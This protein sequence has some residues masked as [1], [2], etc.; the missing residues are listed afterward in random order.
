[1][2]RSIYNLLFLTCFGISAPFYFLRLRRRGNWRPNFGERFGHYDAKIKQ[3]LTNRQTIWM[4]AVSVGEVQVC[5]QLIRA[6]EPRLPNV[7]FVVSTTTS[8]G[9]GELKR[10]LPNHISRIYYPLDYY[11]CV[12]R[13][14][15]SIRPEAIVLIEAEIWPNFIWRAQELR[16]PLFLAN[17]RLSES[18]FRGYKRFGF[19][20]RKLFAGFEGVGA[21]NEQDAARW[22]QLGCP[23]ESVHV[24]GSLKFDTAA[25][26]E[27]RA[28]DVFSLLAQT[29]VKP[30]TPILLG[31]STHPG[32]ETMLARIFLELRKSFPDLFL[33]LVPRHFERGKE[34]GGQLESLGIKF[35]Y[36]T[37]ITSQTSF[38]SGSQQCL[39]V[40]STGELKFFYQAATVVFIGKSMLAE[41][42]Q[43]PIEPAAQG[44]AI[45]FGPHMQNFKEIS[46]HFLRRDAA[47]QVASIP[48]L[49]TTLTTLLS[50]S[51]RRD[52]LGQNARAAVKENLGA[53]DRTAAMIIEN[54]AGKQLYVAR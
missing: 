11:S 53:V 49:Q 6:L 1:V 27:R 42:G 13:A 15:N 48:E 33:L 36:R 25:V 51:A 50:D 44:K 8:T 12:R 38:E 41:G 35:V 31:G 47:V 21:Q 2:L 24:V 32:E 28:L 9:M 19:I 7:K 45:V 14:L 18:S 10:Q 30:G 40:N 5:T 26:E 39:L 46:A 37:E 23:R 22:V 34:V 29:G 17:A 20:F 3:A 16:I 54:L 43:N 52:S 4:H